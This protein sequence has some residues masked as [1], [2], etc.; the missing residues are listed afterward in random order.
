MTQPFNEWLQKDSLGELHSIKLERIES[1]RDV[2]DLSMINPDIQ[3][4]QALLDRLVEATVKPVNSRYSVSRGITRLRQAFADKYHECFKV[5]LDPEKEICI[6]MGAK[7][8]LL[9]LLLAFQLDQGRALLLSP[10]YPAHRDALMLSRYSVDLLPEFSEESQTLEEMERR[11]KSGIDVAVVNF[12]QN[13]TGKMVSHNFL[14]QLV[15][16]GRR[17]KVCLIHD[18]VYAELAFSGPAPSILSGAEQGDEV[19]EIYSLSKGYSIPGWR[20]ASLAGKSNFMR[21]FMKLKSHL[22]YGIFLPIQ[23]AAAYALAAGN[24]EVAETREQYR[25]RA[26]VLV[27]GLKRLGWQVEMPSGGCSVWGRY[28]SEIL[29]KDSFEAAKVLLERTGIA[30][31]PG[32]YFPGASTQHL[33]FAL[34]KPEEILQRVI[35]R[36][37]NSGFAS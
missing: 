23:H 35:A 29:P 10:A 28:S 32:D 9:Q 5:V 30:V 12:P 8:A 37:E 19:Y 36:L 4:S 15:E 25:C 6:T 20:V 3:V 1:G 13:P 7:D 31:L 27:D 34:V 24:D 2:T 26:R 16:L 14:E 18:F 21:T 33:R 17:Y 11:F 22:D